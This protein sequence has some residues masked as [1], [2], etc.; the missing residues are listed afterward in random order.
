[1][2]P[3]RNATLALALVLSLASLAPSAFAQTPSCCP[4]VRLLTSSGEGTLS[5]VPDE[6]TIVFGVVTT[7][8]D[9]EVALL[10]NEQASAAALTSLRAV[11]GVNASQISLTA[12]SLSPRTEYVKNS[13]FEGSVDAGFEAARQIKVVVA[14]AVVPAAVAAVVSSGAN[15]VQ[16]VSYGLSQ[17][18]RSAA[19]RDALGLA[20]TDARARALAMAGQ[21]PGQALG[22]A[23]SVNEGSVSVPFGP[24][25]MM[26]RSFSASADAGLGNPEAFAQGT[27]EVRA[28]V[29]ATW[30]LL[31]V[32]AA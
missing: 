22:P 14:P 6:A 26:A 28:S 30:D 20:V 16:S 31:V 24:S 3:P 9:P 13:T 10:L 1:M 8:E 15:R 5:L 17:P 2:A 25:P 21:L 32:A 18:T 29:S 12:L 27:V 7:N 4:V 23:Q 11:D 19:T